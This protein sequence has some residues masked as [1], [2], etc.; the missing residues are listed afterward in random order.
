[1]HLGDDHEYLEIVE[2][3][4]GLLDE[5]V[6]DIWVLRKDRGCELPSIFLLYVGSW[7]GVVHGCPMSFIVCQNGLM[8]VVCIVGGIQCAGLLAPYLANLL[9]VLL[10]RITSVHNFLFGR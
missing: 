5:L 2:W 1:M 4:K 3:T 10:P 6:Y 8:W 7:M 9:A